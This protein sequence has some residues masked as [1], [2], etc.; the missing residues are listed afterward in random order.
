MLGYLLIVA[1][2]CLTTAVTALFCSTIFRKTST[3][4]ISTYLLIVSLFTVPVAAV[5]FAD[6]FFPSSQGAMVAQFSG[7]LSPFA[8]TFALPLEIDD[9]DQGVVAL[10]LFFGFMAWAVIW[11]GT[12]FVLMTRLFEAR[13][14]VSQ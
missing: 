12:L 4:L 8:A 3:S 14:R 10:P 6:T 5:F 1:V 13:W 2:T 9:G 7:L 11:N